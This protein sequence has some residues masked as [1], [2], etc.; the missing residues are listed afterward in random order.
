MSRVLQ[1]MRGKKK[2]IISMNVA[3]AEGFLMK[4]IC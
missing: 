3:V 4:M 1:D 2:E